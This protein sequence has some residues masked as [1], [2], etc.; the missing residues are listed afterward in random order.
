MSPYAAQSGGARTASSKTKPKSI[1]DLF[2]LIIDQLDQKTGKIKPDGTCAVS[3]IVLERSVFCEITS[4]C[5]IFAAS[6]QPLFKLFFLEDNH[7]GIQFG[8][9][10]SD[11]DSSVGQAKQE[12]RAT[13]SSRSSAEYVF[14]ETKKTQEDKPSGVHSASQSSKVAPIEV[15]VDSSSTSTHQHE[16]VINVEQSDDLKKKEVKSLSGI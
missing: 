11:T 5:H 4:S 16:H 12:D 13:S 14:E 2:I 8:I 15:I 3:A 9:E 7:L 6:P 10:M 1:I